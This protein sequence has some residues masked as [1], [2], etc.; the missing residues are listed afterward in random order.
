MLSDENSDDLYR[1][2][3]IIKKRIDEQGKTFYYVKWEGYPETA[4]TWE[5]EENLSSMNHLIKI[6]ESRIK[7][8]KFTN[9]KNLFNFNHT[10]SNNID[11]YQL[12]NSS[13]S[14]N[15]DNNAIWTSKGVPTKKIAVKLEMNRKSTPNNKVTSIIRKTEVIDLT[16]SE[17][18]DNLGVCVSSAKRAHYTSQPPKGGPPTM[19]SNLDIDVPYCI[20]Y[21]KKNN[22]GTFAEVEWMPRSDGITP[23]NEL[24]PYRLV[25]EKYPGLLIDFYED[26]LITN[27]TKISQKH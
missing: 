5:P 13:K 9:S 15:F 12:S 10:T 11:T 1:I 8:T 6:F 20:R 27:K 3:K 2:E 26:R 24:V 17:H 14:Q 23:N 19:P 22:N 4:N 21:V 7:N 25:R 18:G 16:G